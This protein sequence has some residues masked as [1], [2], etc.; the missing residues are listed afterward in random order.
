MIHFGFSLG[1][2]PQFSETTQIPKKIFPEPDMET[3]GFA[4]HLEQNR[5]DGCFATQVG[6]TTNLVKHWLRWSEVTR[7]VFTWSSTFLRMD[8]HGIGKNVLKKRSIYSGQTKSGVVS[9]CLKPHPIV[10]RIGL[11]EVRPLQLRLVYNSIHTH[12][13]HVWYIF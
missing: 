8:L 3:L 6:R 7:K 4:Q 9:P 2:I 10:Q 13:I 11:S 5:A 1:G 12:R